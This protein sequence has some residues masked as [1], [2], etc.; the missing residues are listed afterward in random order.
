MF[1][2]VA[3][4]LAPTEVGSFLSMRCLLHCAMVCGASTFHA[5]SGLSASEPH[6]EAVPLLPV[7]VA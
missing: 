4:A 6:P 2:A 7:T 1:T 5:A 3:A